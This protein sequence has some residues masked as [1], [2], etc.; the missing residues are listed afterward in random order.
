LQEET[1]KII[2]SLDKVRKVTAN[3]KEILKD[4]G[5]GM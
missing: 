1:R 5:L 3:G 2:L 4:I